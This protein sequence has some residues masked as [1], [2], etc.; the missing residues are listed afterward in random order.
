MEI[1]IAL[2]AHFPFEEIVEV[3]K[4][5]GIN[6]TFIGSETKEFDK[7]MQLFSDNGIICDSLHAPF[8]NI[9]DMWKED[10]EAA[11]AMLLRLKDS[12]DKCAKFSIPNTVV[13]ISSKTPMPEITEK[14]VKRF[15]ELFNYAKEKGVLIALENQRFLE[16]IDFF[17]KRYQDLV[18]CWDSGHENCFTDGVDFLSL[19]GE[20]LKMLHLHDNN[21][22]YDGDE[23]LLPFD[24]K[25]DFQRASDHLSRLNYQGTLML[26]VSKFSTSNGEKIYENLSLDEYIGKAKKALLKLLDM[27]SK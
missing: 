9:N 23:H 17:M 1:G 19:Y 3:Y 18:F 6:H 5:H 4:K 22:V 12:V 13:H 20:R 16:N 21:C 26:E 15:E 8:N 10:D 2:F 27:I 11:N 25:I 7:V 24:G 14:G